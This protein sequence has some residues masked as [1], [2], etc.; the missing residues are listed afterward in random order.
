MDWSV[1]I[2][3]KDQVDQK[4]EI[5]SGIVPYLTCRLQVEKVVLVMKYSVRNYL[6]DQRRYLHSIQRFSWDDCYSNWTEKHVLTFQSISQLLRNTFLH[7]IS[8]FEV[9]TAVFQT[10]YKVITHKKKERKRR[11]TGKQSRPRWRRYTYPPPGPWAPFLDSIDWIYLILFLLLLLSD[12]DRRK[13][14]R[15]RKRV[16]RYRWFVCDMRLLSDGAVHH[17]RV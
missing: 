17:R 11:T 4:S 14:E 8:H 13:Q 2:E 3:G 12:F 6:V 15:E 5:L 7:L 10:A 1:S 16:G 9:E